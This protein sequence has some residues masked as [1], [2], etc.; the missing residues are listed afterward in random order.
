MGIFFRKSVKVAPGVRLNFSKRGTSLSVGPKGAKINYSKRGTYLT[1]SIPGTGIY[2]RTKIGSG[3]N[4][5][6][7]RNFS[8]NSDMSQKDI[9]KHDPAALGCGIFAASVFCSLFCALMAKSWVVIPII[10]GIGL[11]MAFIPSL[12]ASNNETDETNEML[13]EQNELDEVERDVLT[14]KPI[15]ERLNTLL[16]EMDKAKTETGLVDIHNKIQVLMNGQLKGKRILFNGMSFDDAMKLIETEYA[17]KM[18]EVNPNAI[19]EYDEGDSFNS[20][21]KSSISIEEQ[22][23][24][25]TLVQKIKDKHT[26]IEAMNAYEEAKKEMKQYERKPLILIDGMGYEETLEMI[27][28]TYFNKC[29]ELHS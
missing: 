3:K 16:D 21:K 27:H 29:K 25:R 8:Q 24:L 10:S 18:K 12:F 7:S 13:K 17:K 14:S 5:T 11:L 6:A 19:L 4:Q 26:M 1:T 9:A 2:S 28:Q 20:V 23:A 22:E 15:V